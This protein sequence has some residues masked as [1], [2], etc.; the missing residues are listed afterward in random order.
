VLLP[1]QNVRI[2]LEKGRVS[3]IA[4]DRAIL[5]ILKAAVDFQL[6]NLCYRCL[7]TLDARSIATLDHLVRDLRQLSNGIARLRA[8]TPRT[9]EQAGVREDRPCPI[10]FRDIHRGHRAQPF[11]TSGLGARLAMPNQPAVPYVP[12]IV[13]YRCA[14]G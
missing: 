4:A 1:S 9:I 13:R 8:T 14:S 3:A 5:K 2:L 7:K 11:R 6:A 12:T 10:R